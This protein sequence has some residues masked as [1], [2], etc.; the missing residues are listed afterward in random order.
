MKMSVALVFALAGSTMTA[1]AAETYTC[2]SIVGGKPFTIIVDGRDRVATIPVKST[3]PNCKGIRYGAKENAKTF[4]SPYPRESGLVY[5]P[6]KRIKDG[7][8]RGA[9]P[10]FDYAYFERN[11]LEGKSYGKLVGVTEF[12]ERGDATNYHY[13][14][15]AN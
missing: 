12:F 6:M 8:C 14:C 11:L 10:K 7:T 4:K 15:E 13:D 9:E 2:S 5:L 1:F 3:S